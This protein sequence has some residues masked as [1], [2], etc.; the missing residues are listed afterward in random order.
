MEDKIK[1]TLIEI[2]AWIYSLSVTFLFLK[3]SLEG[4]FRRKFNL[5]INKKIRYNTRRKNNQIESHNR[6]EF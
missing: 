3:M 1:N 5:L 6:K 2:L 4:I